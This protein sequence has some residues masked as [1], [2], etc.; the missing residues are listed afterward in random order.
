MERALL[1]E[2]SSLTLLVSRATGD[3][4]AARGGAESLLGRPPQEL[5]GQPILGLA[6][7]ETR[8]FAFKRGHVDEPGFFRE[9]R[10]AAGEGEVKVV[11]LRVHHLS[12]EVALLRMTDSSD[13]M[14]LTTELREVHAQLHTA[15]RQ[16]KEQ[17]SALDEARRAASLSLFA[18]GLAH[19]LNNPLAFLVSTANTVAGHS[20]ELKEVWPTGQP[21]EEIEDLREM[22][23]EI[24]TGLS[25]ITAVVR[26]LGELEHRTNHASFDVVSLIRA[27][28]V[29]MDPNAIFDGPASAPA[30]SDP[31]A[32]VRCLQRTVDNARKAAG[33]RGRVVVQL[34][35]DATHYSLAVVDDGPGIPA[36]LVERVFDPFFTTRAPGAGLGLGLFLA[37]RAVAT[38]EGE[39]RVE[40]VPSGARLVARF[41]KV[42]KAV[43]A[44]RTSYE[45]LR[46]PG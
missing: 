19:E 16:L 29:K 30:S 21:P 41:P 38:I 43:S 3:I 2:D 44:P 14:A 45:A 24:K 27:V 28:L 39:L 11:A 42:S 9:L 20:E 31:D 12:A 26:Q 40:S 33:A 6:P 15:F 36:G 10:I 23:A 8:G 17:Q 22:A 4:L 32:V 46:S 1:D 5:V 7:K 13:Q 18:A 34:T 37:R 25:R 35:S